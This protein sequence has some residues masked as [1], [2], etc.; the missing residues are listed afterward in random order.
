MARHI[1]VKI[2]AVESE[3]LV[4]DRAWATRKEHRMTVS[5][6]PGWLNWACSGI[7]NRDR[8][9]KGKQRTGAWVL[10]LGV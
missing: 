3:G 10:W 8:A 5:R 6:L 2:L 7:V 1:L 4:T 9:L